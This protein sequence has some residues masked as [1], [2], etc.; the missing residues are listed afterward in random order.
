MKN[1]VPQETQT[2]NAAFEKLF[3]DEHPRCV[4]VAR[5][6]VGCDD[7]AHDIAAEALTRAW[8]R[9]G[10]LEC[11]RPGAWVVTVTTNL[12]IDA[13]R[14]RI[15]ALDIPTSTDSPEDRVVTRAL[16]TNALQSLTAQQQ[17]AIV[18]RFTDGLSV[19]EIADALRVSQG[20]VKTHLHRGIRRLR[21]LLDDGVNGS[22]RAFVDESST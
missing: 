4:R 17:R 16:L 6:I 15:P 14:R 11:Q 20:T 3:R 19:E 9:W 21:T 2:H 13:V 22:G 5:R 18:L 7:L 12:A 1:G 8:S 10:S